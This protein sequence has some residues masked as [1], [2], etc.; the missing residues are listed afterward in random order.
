M[1]LCVGEG[2]AEIA[3]VDEMLDEFDVVVAVGADVDFGAGPRP[4]FSSTQ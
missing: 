3:D 2:P 4:K 1:P